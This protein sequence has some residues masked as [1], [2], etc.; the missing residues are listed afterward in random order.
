MLLHTTAGGNLFTFA[1]ADRGSK[2]KVG[3]IVL[4]SDHTS[5]SR[6]RSDIKHQDFTLGELGNFPSLL[7]TFCPHTQ[8]PPKL[9][10]IKGPDVSNDS[11][12]LN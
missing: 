3:K 2:L 6:H 7:C 11:F 12:I 5:A 4:D 8:Q 10:C 9:I 1:C